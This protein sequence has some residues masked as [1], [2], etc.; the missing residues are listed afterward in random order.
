[1]QVTCKHI[2]AFIVCIIAGILIGLLYKGCS[3]EPTQEPQPIHDTIVRVDSVIVPK[4]RIK[5]VTKTDT[6]ILIRTETKTDTIVIELPVE[7]KEY[8]DSIV[9]DS[10]RIAW[11]V[12]YSGYRAKI[13]TFA[14]DYT[15]QPQAQVIEKKNGWGSFV[16]VGVGIGG[17]IGYVDGKIQPTPHAGIHIVYGW[18]YHW[19]RIKK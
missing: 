13:D 8:A 9:T 17:G 5:Y 16:G 19:K 18:G 3:N 14:L 7:H 11:N 15:I 12:Q 4:T 1:M 6:A 10:A 2:I